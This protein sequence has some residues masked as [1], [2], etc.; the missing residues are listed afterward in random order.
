MEKELT[1]IKLGGSLLT[2]KSRP[3]EARKS[4]IAAVAKELKD[5]KDEGL[6]QSLVIIHGVG[7]FGHPPVLQYKL[8]KGFTGPEQFI[9]LS[10]TQSIVN[11]FRL[12]IT[13]E[14][15]EAGL[16]VNLLHPSSMLVAEKMRVTKTSFEPLKGWM[17]LG[18][19]PILGGDLLYDKTMG[20]SIGSGD[21]LAIILA[22]DLRAKRLIFAMDELGVYDEDPK[23]NPHAKL[24]T[25][26]DINDLDRVMEGLEQLGKVD[27]S[28]AMK[29]KLSY[30]SVVKDLIEDGLETT[31]I[32]MMKYGNLKALLKG[33]NV[34]CTKIVSK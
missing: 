12:M 3:Y 30:I 26:I 19:I 20:F 16:P 31:L 7:S 28:G 18:M 22:R 24:L 15:Q 5:C 9:P 10:K 6:I 33:L 25:E 4:I 17:T 27:A 29:G 23:K 2:D 8:Y 1:V 11:E 13:K 14:F 32:S 34:N 21:E